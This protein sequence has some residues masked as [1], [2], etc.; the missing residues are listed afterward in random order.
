MMLK[1]S[2]CS[3][4]S[5]TSSYTASRK[6]THDLIDVVSQHLSANE[7]RREIVRLSARYEVTEEEE[8]KKGEMLLSC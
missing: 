3:M 7:M 8:E 2:L 6:L 4:T 5:I 1:S